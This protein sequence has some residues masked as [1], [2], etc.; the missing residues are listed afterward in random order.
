M[1]LSSLGPHLAD[2]D[3]IGPDLRNAM[4]FFFI[5][6]E[7]MDQKAT[8]AIKAIGDSS[9]NHPSAWAKGG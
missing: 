2:G 3:I 8:N 7:N 9:I 4:S 6:F 1:D 5:K